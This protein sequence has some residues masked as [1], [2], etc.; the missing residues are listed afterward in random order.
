MKKTNYLA[1]LLL[2]VLSLSFANASDDDM[3]MTTTS[4]TMLSDDLDNSDD[5]MDEDESMDDSEDD[6]EDELED[7][8]EDED[9]SM[10]DSAMKHHMI[11]M[12]GSVDG[13]MYK[14]INIKDIRKEKRE[15]ISSNFEALKENRSI[16]KN[17]F[18][19]RSELKWLNSELQKEIKVINDTFKEESKLLEDEIKANKWDLEKI[20]EIRDELNELRVSYYEELISI[21]DDTEV[22]ESLTSRLELLKENIALI[23]SNMEA[24]VEFRWKLNDKVTKYKDVLETK[25]EKGLPKIKEDK[26]ENVLSKIDKV[27]EVI[28][29][30]TKISQTKKDQ[31][32]SQIIALKELL[33]EELESKNLD[34]SVTITE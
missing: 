16:I 22:K 7:D 2:L 14:N 8:S 13:R 12:S 34:S 3:Q 4:S 27:T 17:E 19:L 26:L 6:S 33:E 15:V 30:N 20:Q 25:L 18:S 10:D 1:L 9:E 23:D 21:V 32:L 11:F 24:R 5:D 31:I 29:N 28:E